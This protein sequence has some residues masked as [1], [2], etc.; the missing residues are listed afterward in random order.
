MEYTESISLP[1]EL[2]MKSCGILAR[3]SAQSVSMIPRFDWSSVN[4]KPFSC[5][6]S[7][8]G[9]HNW[10]AGR[11]ITSQRWLPDR[12]IRTSPKVDAAVGT[13]GAACPTWKL[14]AVTGPPGTT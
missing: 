9:P 1:S 14:L 11:L 4:R 12:S 6:K 10:S 7:R 2:R 5:Q 13:E 3:F 8:T